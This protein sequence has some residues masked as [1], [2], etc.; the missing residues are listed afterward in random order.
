M[1]QPH[2][3]CVAMLAILICA[4]GGL[5]CSAD[6]DRVIDAKADAQLRRMCDLLAKS[7]QFRARVETTEDDWLSPSQMVQRVSEREVFLWRPDRFLIRTHG[8]VNR[9][10]CYS[11]RHLVVLDEDQDA[12]A[13]ADGPS[14]IDEVIDEAVEKLDVNIPLADFLMSDPYRAFTETVNSGEYLGEHQV[15]EHSCHHLAF[16]QDTIDWQIWIDAG[17]LPLPWK[18]V[19]T[20]KSE[21]GSPQY[22][23]VFQEWDLHPRSFT[24]EM[25]R[26]SPPPGAA[27][28]KM[29]ELVSAR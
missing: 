21:P 3:A 6:R 14:R 2:R 26:L 27:T 17:R 12:Y 15:E 10:A 11:D 28:V 24:P 16:R 13:T 5:G 4:L 9:T 29:G 1:C 19:I 18:F 8:A 20:Y 23:A 7:Q 22:A 25:F